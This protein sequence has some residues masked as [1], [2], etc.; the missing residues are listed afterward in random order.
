MDGFINNLV[1]QQKSL[2]LAL[3]DPCTPNEVVLEHAEDVIGAHEH[4]IRQV[5]KHVVELRSKLPAVNRDYL[6][7]LCA[8][9]L[10]GPMSR[11]GGRV[12]GGRRRNG[13][14]PGGPDGRDYGYGRGGGAGRGGRGGYGM[15]LRVRDRLTRRLGLDEEQVKILEE[16]DPDF[17]TNSMNLRYALMTEREKLLFIFENPG[18]SDDELLKQIENFI[19]TYSSIE[20]RIAEHVLVL[21]PYLTVEQ[22]K[23]LIGLCRRTQTLM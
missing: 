4:L 16:K 18:S 9:T 23:W 8:Q 11:L 20:R 19:S 7:Q 1:T 5:G 12:G 22:Q 15:R 14:G 3:E 6:M 13:T 2:A 10:R 21:R 17:E